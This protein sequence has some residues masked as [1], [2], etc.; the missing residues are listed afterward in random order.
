[1]ARSGDVVENPVTRERIIWRK[2]ARDTG[3]E[4]LQADLTVG[5]GGFAAA[6]HVHPKQE[7]RFE[8]LEGTLQLRLNGNEKTMR[9]GEVAV[10]PAG[11]PHVWW[12][13]GDDELHALFELRPALRTEIFFETFFGL[14]K[15]GKTNKKGLPN[16]LRIAVAMREYE[17][18]LHL[19]RPP[20][21]VQKALFWP[22]A[23]LGRLLGYR[24]WYP[25]YSAEPLTKGS[26]S[27]VEV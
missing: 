16:L 9:A 14:A 12:N 23:M 5:A 11:R 24:G 18:E 2:V 8:V 4:L 1:M 22:L 3:G 10:V 25:Q 19:A 20:L 15:D 26:G 21:I 6:E 27:G 17:D 13:G 7:E